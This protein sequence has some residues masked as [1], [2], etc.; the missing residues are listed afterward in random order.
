MRTVLQHCLEV[1]NCCIWSARI[2]VGLLELRQRPPHSVQN[3]RTLLV[4]F[5]S[6]QRARMMHIDIE[7]RRCGTA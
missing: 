3:T 1:L 2:P 5:Y 4:E 7:L 6:A